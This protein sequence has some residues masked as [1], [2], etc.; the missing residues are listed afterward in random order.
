M[1]DENREQIRQQN[2]E[3]F[4]EPLT[5]RE[6]VLSLKGFFTNKN[7]TKY[8]TILIFWQVGFSPVECSSDTILL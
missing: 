7:L 4:E 3:S 5:L 1:V 6:L 2:K 8:M